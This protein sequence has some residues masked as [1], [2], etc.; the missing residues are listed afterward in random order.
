MIQDTGERINA[1]TVTIAARGSSVATDDA[2]L[3]AVAKSGD[4][5][6]FELLVER[7]GRIVL[8]TVLRITGNRE[9]AE[10]VVQQSFQKAFVHLKEFQRRSSFSTWLT[11]NVI[12]EALM[13][14]RNGR[15]WREVSMVREWNHKSAG[16]VSYGGYANGSRAVE[17]LRFVMGELHVADVRAHVLLSLFTDFENFSVFK[18]AADREASVIAISGTGLGDRATENGLASRFLNEPLRES[19]SNEESNASVVFVYLAESTPAEPRTPKKTRELQNSRTDFA[20]KTP[21]YK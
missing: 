7:Y 2:T 18:P 5:E 1:R 11:R 13:S 10:D 21:L 12:N 14:R 8:F 4:D 16:F 20:E 17:H 15:R 9:D 3:V 19:G 6:S